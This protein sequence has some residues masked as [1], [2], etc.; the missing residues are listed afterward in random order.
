[1]I[2]TDGEIFIS[3]VDTIPLFIVYEMVMNGQKTRFQ[4]RWLKQKLL[5]YKNTVGHSVYGYVE[6][7]AQDIQI[8][9]HLRCAMKITR[10]IIITTIISNSIIVACCLDLHIKRV[11]VRDMD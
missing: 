11:C 7:A 2:R 8:F 9:S 6:V 1:M 3:V 10:I 5:T 4:K